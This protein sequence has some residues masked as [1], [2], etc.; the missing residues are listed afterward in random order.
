MNLSRA[1]AR[2]KDS[3]HPRFGTSDPRETTPQD[4][5]RSRPRLWLPKRPPYIRRPAEREKLRALCA[6]TRYRTAT[7]LKIFWRDFPG[8]AWSCQELALE[9]GVHQ[10]T[11]EKAIAKLV[12]WGLLYTELSRSATNHP[13]IALPPRRWIVDPIKKV[14]GAT[15]PLSPSQS[16]NHDLSPSSMD[17]RAVNCEAED[18]T[19]IRPPI[20]HARS[21]SHTSAFQQKP[22]SER[23]NPRLSHPVHVPHTTRRLIELRH[24]AAG[25]GEV[26]QVLREALCHRYP[27]ESLA[28]AL[29]MPWR[30]ARSAGKLFRKLFRE[31]LAGRIDNID[32]AEVARHRLCELN[33]L[34][35]EYAFAD[36]LDQLDDETLVGLRADLEGLAGI[37]VNKLKHALIDKL[38]ARVVVALE[39]RPTAL[40]LLKARSIALPVQRYEPPVS[41]Q[42]MCDRE[43]RDALNAAEAHLLETV[44]PWDHAIT[45]RA[46]RALRDDL[47][48]RTRLAAASSESAPAGLPEDP[49]EQQW[50]SLVEKADQLD[51]DD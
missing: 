48:K 30:A 4:D 5:L 49:L 50:A 3:T 33:N 28:A 23:R 44:D 22:R 35:A 47:Y 25:L 40:T 51:A 1:T 29:K 15:P 36:D 2:A 21:G 46:I 20:I 45:T 9:L 34:A 13:L 42:N 19:R 16:V 41:L 17:R 43:V 12:R 18:P 38:L 6:D 31:A 32:E 11:I 39:A 27:L 14:R 10:S 26:D 37:G 8:V 7:K 24:G